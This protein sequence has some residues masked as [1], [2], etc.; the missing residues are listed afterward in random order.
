MLL[1][2]LIIFAAAWAVVIYLAN[3]LLAGKLL[4][5]ELKT[6]IFYSATVALLGVIAEISIGTFY[7]FLF[8]KPLWN[9]TVY[10]AFNAYTSEYAPILWAVYGFQI[11]LLHEYLVNK[12]ITS[13][14]LMPLIF[15]IE[16]IVL[17]LLINFTF[18][19]V[20]GKFV[21]YYY[22]GDLW[23]FTSVQTL[24]FYVGA[25]IVI[26]MA[27]KRF[28]KKPIFCTITFSLIVFLLT[29]LV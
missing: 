14:L 23:H 4:R 24:P 15:C 18:L 25:G 17:E 8:G 19:A 13:R 5:P 10:P 27:L 7:H 22:P 21:Y 12:N 29:S 6:A 3:S 2:F 9:Y 16:A 1:I 11:Y 28:G 20:F 26:P